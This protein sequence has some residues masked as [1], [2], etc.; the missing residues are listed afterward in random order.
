MYCIFCQRYNKYRHVCLACRTGFVNW[1]TS[2]VVAPEE[3]TCSLQLACHKLLVFKGK[4]ACLDL[5]LTN[6][7][8]D[9]PSE[10]PGFYKGNAKWIIPNNIV[11]LPEPL[12]AHNAA[13]LLGN[14]L[15]L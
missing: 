2:H 3:S 9:N 14:S 11:R 12:H 8:S 7:P 13:T 5:D 1:V 10:W 15:N 4:S 6:R